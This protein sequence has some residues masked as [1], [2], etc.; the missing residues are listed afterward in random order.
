MWLKVQAISILA[1]SHT[2]NQLASH[3]IYVRLPE[4]KTSILRRF[5]QQTSSVT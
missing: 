5:M 3:T 2:R 4:S 1:L